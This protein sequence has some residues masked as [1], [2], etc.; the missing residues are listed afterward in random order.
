MLRANRQSRYTGNQ[1]TQIGAA[2]SAA[3][4]RTAMSKHSSMR[5]DAARFGLLAI[6]VSATVVACG[7]GSDGKDGDE[8][9]GPLASIIT[10]ESTAQVSQTIIGLDP[11]NNAIWVPSYTKDGDGNLQY[12]VVPTASVVPG[13][14][15]AAVDD[16]RK[17][18]LPGCDSPVGIAYASNAKTFLIECGN[19]ASGQLHLQVVSATDFSV[20][21]MALDG[22]AWSEGYGGIVYNPT[23]HRAVIAGSTTMGLLD[24]PDSGAPALNTDSVT[25][26]P[27]SVQSMSLNFQTG[28]ALATQGFGVFDARVAPVMIDTTAIHAG[29]ASPLSYDG[30]ETGIPAQWGDSDGFYNYRYG[31]GAVFD[32]Q[33]HVLALSRMTDNSFRNVGSFDQ[34]VFTYNLD[35]LHPGTPE[36]SITYDFIF[37][38]LLPIDLPVSDY[39]TLEQDWTVPAGVIGTLYL[40]PDDVALSEGD[41]VHAGQQLWAGYGTIPAGA[42]SPVSTSITVVTPATPSMFD[43]VAVPG[44]GTNMVQGQNVGGVA[45]LN[46]TT[47]QALIAD[48]FGPNFVVVQLPTSPVVGALDNKGQPVLNPETGR[49]EVTTTPSASSAYGLFSGYVPPAYFDNAFHPFSILGGP[50]AASIDQVNN[51]AYLLA[52]D[53]V[54]SSG[55]AT[56]PAWS[57]TTGLKLHLVAVDLSNPKAS[58]NGGSPYF[59]NPS[60]SITVVG[61]P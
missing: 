31:N 6:G 14:D 42:P 56:H 48:A 37:G 34:A 59:M 52:D 41:V 40:Y 13:V 7:G 25:T 58:E 51:I 22:F 54:Y 9:N 3:A 53:F 28:Q 50:A 18:S 38:N 35:A 44:I 29:D 4:R 1:T 8:G 32:P 47:H 49:L 33:T 20:T 27:I 60:A 19:A 43:Y 36:T 30:F 21:S 12:L 23:N 17:V 16:P 11:I 45:A 24:V 15:N 55:G 46:M 26:L 10:P 2:L 61:L 57:T 39:W 5:R